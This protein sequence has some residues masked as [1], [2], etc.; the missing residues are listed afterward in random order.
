M[1]TGQEI[2]KEMQEKFAKIKAK[3]EQFKKGVLKEFPK[4]ISGLA[5]LPPKRDNKKGFDPV[6]PNPVKEEDK[7]KVNVLV[8]INDPEKKE[9]AFV[10]REKAIKKISEIAKKID[11]NIQ[12][13]VMLL[14]ELRES[15]FDGK[16]ELLQ[17]VAFGAILHDPTDILAALKISE[18]HKTMV[19]KKFDKYI[20]SY[21]AAG[22][23]FRGDKKSNDIDV[24]VIV[25]DTDVKRMSRFEL[26]DKLRSIIIQQG[27]EAARLTGVNKQ[28]HVQTYILTDFWESVKD[29]N[30]V[31]FTFL[32]DGVPLYDR[33]VFA[34]WRLLLKMG[35]VKPS[36]EAIDMQMDIG[37]KLLVRTKGKL[38][39]VVGED[40]YYAAL[41]PA[42]AALMLYGVNPPTPLETIQLLREIF[43]KKEK[44]LEEKYVKTLEEIRTY[45]KAIEHG[46]V[47]E[48]K[49]SEIDRLLKD[50]K[51]YL[52]R[53]KKLF[54]HLD[55]N[56][57]RQTVKDINDLCNNIV[58]EVVQDFLGETKNI[59]AGFK[60]LITQKKIP[61]QFN[62]IYQRIVKSKN[63]K[64]SKPEVEKLRRESN[65]FLNGLNEVVQRKH[66][67]DIERN[68]IRV[69]HGEEIGEVI[70]G[71]RIAFIIKNI[72]TPKEVKKAILASNGRLGDLE[73]SSLKEM[74]DTL[75]DVKDLE[76]LKLNRALY[77]S[78]RMYF[79][80]DV[81]II[82]G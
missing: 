80:D 4:Q 77:S 53:I 1:E 68:K 36:P 58:Q 73:K 28:F 59:E 60:K 64:L 37:D 8:L 15:L 62:E 50:V 54:D 75:R 81:E 26:K 14:A 6:N 17:D 35:R 25:D 19:I 63:K 72:K 2:P 20:M 3:V 13:E 22:S 51:A 41:N 46:K 56:K 45:Y 24:Y 34:P 47:K 27:F 52:D 44:L 23:L 66:L 67:M 65:L 57:E 43:V 69:K 39:S 49:G 31:I 42:Q 78:L 61:K 30:P 11:E 74:N 18:V 40:L 5:I 70:L 55:K 21:I 16:Q 38:L 12:P 79:G 48:V 7:K 29:A 9:D 82:L 10:V 33:G 32:R 71:K 76:T